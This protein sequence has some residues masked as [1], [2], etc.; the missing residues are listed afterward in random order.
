MSDT[1]HIHNKRGEILVGYVNFF[2]STQYGDFMSW[3]LI[4]LGVVIGIKIVS[5]I[6]EKFVKNFTQK[7]KTTLDDKLL[8]AFEKSLMVIA[9]IIL[10]YIATNDLPLFVKHAE[11]VNKILF[12]ITV[13]G[14]AF[15]LIR[16]ILALLTW[17]GEEIAE[18]TESEIDDVFIPILL[19]IS[20]II[21][22]IIAL[23]IVLAKFG[24]SLTPILASLGVASVAI[25]LALKDTLA[26]FFAGF[27]VMADRPVKKGDFIK[28]ENGSEGTVEDIGWRTSKVRTGDNVV[29]FVPNSKLATSIVHNYNNSDKNNN[30]MI[31]GGVSYETDLDKAEKILQKVAKD[32]IKE[33]KGCIKNF[34]PIVRFTSF[35]ESNIDFVVIVKVGKYPERGPIIHDLIKRTKKVFD[36]A[37]IEMNYPARKIYYGKRRR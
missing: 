20:G 32:V 35:G 1:E 26:E 12:I 9:V 7:T 25:A 8:E 28:L 29:I 24:I 18:K 15:V 22:Y 2:S 16:F 31:K 6:I 23:I 17:Y 5:W 11:L 36:K 10:A 3:A 14:A 33:N 21:I 4:F 34:K 19:K 37:R 30:I 27:Y 13:F